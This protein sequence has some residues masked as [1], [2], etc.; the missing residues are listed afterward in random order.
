[1]L[2]QLSGSPR[3]VQRVDRW[4]ASILVVEQLLI[5]LQAGRGVRSH[6]NGATP[7]DLVVVAL[8]GLGVTVIVVMMVQ[9][10]LLL[11]KTPQ[12]DPAWRTALRAGL[13]PALRSE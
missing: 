2:G 9:T 6:F 1:V 10:A 12:L 4:V 11:A 13:W 7:F 8:M 5:V 3:F